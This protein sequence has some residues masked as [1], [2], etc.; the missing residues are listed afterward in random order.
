MTIAVPLET[1]APPKPFHQALRDVGILAA[2]QRGGLLCHEGE[3]SSHVLL[4]A[5]GFVVAV[6]R[7]AN[8]EQQN[9]AIYLPGDLVD[10]ESFT[11]GATRCGAIAL[12]HV[13]YH[14]VPHA[15][16]RELL[17]VDAGHRAA[18]WRFVAYHGALAHEWLL[19][20][21]RRSAYAR[22]AHFLCEIVYRA[23]SGHAETGSCLMPLTQSELAD[24]LGLSVVHV[25]RTLM[26]L[27]QERLIS[28]RR[29]RV[30]VLDWPR[31]RAAAGFN[32]SY[33]A[34]EV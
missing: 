5:S 23:G 13:S 16:L 28:L 2:A 9:V 26:R 32:P 6:K 11:L 29:G 8:G 24:T 19:S 34:L 31:F 12:T 22:T 25:N 27:K 1:T 21:G 20:L 15:R 30:E 18:F 14:R 4:L 10:H 7:T 17:E 33:L 3:A